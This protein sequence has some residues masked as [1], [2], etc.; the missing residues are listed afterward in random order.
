MYFIA[1]PALLSAVATNIKIITNTCIE[2]VQQLGY[3]IKKPD[4]ERLLSKRVLY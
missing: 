1:H 4:D 3:N 2:D